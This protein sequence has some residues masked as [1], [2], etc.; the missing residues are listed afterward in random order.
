VILGDRPESAQ[1][2][3]KRVDG[4]PVS[5]PAA[6]LLQPTGSTLSYL[7]VSLKTGVHLFLIAMDHE[8]KQLS[9]SP[10][11]VFGRIYSTGRHINALTVKGDI[12]YGTPSPLFSATGDHGRTDSED[13]PHAGPWLSSMADSQLHW[14]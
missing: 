1:R 6:T 7:S 13:N 4:P 10:P 14:P 5:C 9:S 11:L 12:S 2:P 3:I 8:D